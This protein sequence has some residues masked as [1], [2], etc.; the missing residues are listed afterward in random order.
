MPK[1]SV[2]RKKVIEILEK[3]R[4]ITWHPCKIRFKQN[5]IFGIIDLLAVRGRQKKNIQITTSTNTSVRR[6][7]ITAFLKK[8]KVEMP[9]EIW[10]WNQKQKKFKK[11]KVNIKLKKEVNRS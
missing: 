7:K 10:S 8:F 1:E 9:V 2:I 6:K 11:E 3:E 5:D 4:W